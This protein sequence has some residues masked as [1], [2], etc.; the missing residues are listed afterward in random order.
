MSTNQHF[1]CLSRLIPPEDKLFRNAVE[2]VQ[3][4]DFD[5]F[6]SE[7]E[8]P[9][10]KHQ[11][12][13]RHQQKSNI[14]SIHYKLITAI[15]L[16]CLAKRCFSDDAILSEFKDQ[17][18]S[19]HSAD[20]MSDKR[21]RDDHDIILP[22]FRQQVNNIERLY[23]TL[24]EWPFFAG[25]LPGITEKFVIFRGF[26][27]SRYNLLFE[28]NDLKNMKR[29][30]VITTPTFLSTSVV[31]DS[32]LR[33]AGDEGYFWEITVPVD[34]LQEFKYVYFGDDT[35]LST[36]GPRTKEGEMLLN[37]GTQLKY[38]GPESEATRYETD[39]EVK[40]LR[41]FSVGAVVVLAP[42]TVIEGGKRVLVKGEQG[43]V[44]EVTDDP[45]D[46]E[47][48]NVMKKSGETYWYESGHLVAAPALPGQEMVWITEG[49][50][51]RVR[52]AGWTNVNVTK[53]CFEFVGYKDSNVHYL[54]NCLE[55]LL[56][57]NSSKK[58]RTRRT[59]RAES[60][61]RKKKKPKK[62][63][64]KKPKKKKQTKKKGEDKSCV[65][66]FKK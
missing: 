65:K 2:W 5:D 36:L 44:F 24:K 32:A 11:Y 15:I 27:M 38:L 53:Q 61:K 60:K 29:G 48:Y 28:Q 63:K 10:S 17:I 31:R 33:F 19:Q 21:G 7:L 8:A 14:N 57:D 16:N 37:I 12:R 64:P 39:E 4:S 46:T 66:S 34:K 35:D 62:K 23:D 1:P 26:D 30:D 43:R 40:S 45:E 25:G 42:G 56:F 18:L 47:P 9:P 6:I 50:N 51:E 55:G 20:Q 3:Q 13:T 59:N 41:E 49:G 52:V 22:Y 54:H 58:Q